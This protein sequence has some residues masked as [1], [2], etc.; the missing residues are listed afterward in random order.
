MFGDG[1]RPV[2]TVVPFSGPDEISTGNPAHL[3]S[4]RPSS[5]NLLPEPRSVNVYCPLCSGFWLTQP[6]SVTMLGLAGGFGADCAGV[7]A[8]E[9]SSA[10]ATAKASELC[11]RKSL[12]TSTVHPNRLR[13]G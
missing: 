3:S 12:R 5:R 13:S 6:L 4:R 10:V 11:I 7:I 9:R 1:Q 8:G 2:E